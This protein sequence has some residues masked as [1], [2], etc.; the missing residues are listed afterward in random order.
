MGTGIQAAQGSMFRT[1]EEI[2]GDPSL[3]LGLEK[4]SAIFKTG[5]KGLTIG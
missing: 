1:A 2:Q 3:V 4:G 5:G